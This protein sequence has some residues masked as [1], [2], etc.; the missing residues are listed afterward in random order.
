MESV[1]WVWEDAL[2]DH[3]SVLEFTI[4]VQETGV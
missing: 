1:N 2:D 3:E 4:S